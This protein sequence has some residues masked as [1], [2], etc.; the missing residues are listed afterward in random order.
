MC[1]SALEWPGGSIPLGASMSLPRA[2]AVRQR[3][4]LA[5]RPYRGSFLPD[6]SRPASSCRPWRRSHAARC[7]A[8]TSASPCA[9]IWSTMRSIPC[10]P[11]VRSMSSRSV[12][13]AGTGSARRSVAERHHD[14]A[15]LGNAPGNVAKA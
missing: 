5:P 2:P 1:L 3:R 11:A 15:L 12:I 8:R 6:W 13:I 7:F 4:G 14:A 9:R 10:L